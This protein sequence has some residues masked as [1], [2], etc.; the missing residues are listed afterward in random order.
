MTTEVSKKAVKAEQPKA[1]TVSALRISELEL[2]VIGDSPLICHAWSEKAK[3]QIRDKQ[4]G[5]GQTAREAKVPHQE[6]RD[7]LYI[8]DDDR[9]YFPSIAFKCAAVDACSQVDG[10]TKVEMR[11][12]FHVMGE[13]SV[14]QSAELTIDPGLAEKGFSDIEPKMREDMVRVGMGSADL[15]YRG[16]FDDWKIRLHIRFN[17]RKF[18]AN[19]IAN[20]FA[21]AGFAVGVGEWRPEKNGNFGMFHVDIETATL[22]GKPI[23]LDIS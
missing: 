15:R 23:K 11:G 16:Q 5:K 7:S 19:Q 18:N 17:E 2:D 20:I 3:K 6:F 13:F 12:I 4:T 8:M 10:I 1:L 21:V 22:N 9:Y 14:I